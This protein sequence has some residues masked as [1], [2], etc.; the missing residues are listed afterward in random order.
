MN[1]YIE[2]IVGGRSEEISRLQDF[3][4]SF[5]T[6]PLASNIVVIAARKLA[7]NIKERNMSYVAESNNSVVEPTELE[8]YAELLHEKCNLLAAIQHGTGLLAVSDAGLDTYTKFVVETLLE[9]SKS[10]LVAVRT[11]LESFDSEE[12]TSKLHGYYKTVIKQL[13]SK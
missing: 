2:R 3:L 12:I 11:E 10:R 4:Y 5:L 1:P 6:F 9:T 7:L 8:K 13:A